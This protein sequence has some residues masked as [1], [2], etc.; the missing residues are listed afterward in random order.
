MYVYKTYTIGILETMTKIG[1]HSL[2][3]NL[4]TFLKKKI[5]TYFYLK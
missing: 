5:F 3:P 2:F 1:E 4:L